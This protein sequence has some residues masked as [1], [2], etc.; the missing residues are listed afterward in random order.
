MS[1]DVPQAQPGNHSRAPGPELG[2]GSSG[3]DAGRRSVGM[4][5]WHTSPFDTCIPALGW[6]AGC[7]SLVPAWPGGAWPC[8]VLWLTWRPS[9]CLFAGCQAVGVLV[10]IW[11]WGEA[12]VGGWEHKSR[13]VRSS[14]HDR[15]QGQGQQD[16][17]F[18]VLRTWTASPA[19]RVPTGVTQELGIQLAPYT[20]A[21]CSTH[22]L[23]R[24]SP[25]AT[26]LLLGR[27]GPAG[28]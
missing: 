19:N 17:Q 20:W 22:R 5:A 1:S 2:S 25:K 27:K 26:Y 13:A 18:P 21:P 14:Q 24:P 15:S 23:P 3:G 28:K 12:G 16:H 9:S 6:S 11:W 10:P 7:P 8:V 4:A